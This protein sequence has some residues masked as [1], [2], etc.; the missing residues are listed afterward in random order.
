MIKKIPKEELF[1]FIMACVFGFALLIMPE[2]YDWLV[3]I[4]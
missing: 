1:L 2:T 4:L 3:S